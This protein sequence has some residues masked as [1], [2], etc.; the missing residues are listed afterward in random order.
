MVSVVHARLFQ[1][2]IASL[3]IIATG[4]GI[5]AVGVARAPSAAAAPDAKLAD[6]SG[7]QAGNIIDD[8]LF[9]DSNALSEAGIQAFLNAKVPTCAAGF[10]CL[11]NYRET[12]H[13]IAGTP[14][15]AQYDG[16]A[17]ESAATIIFKVAQTCGISPKVLLVVLQKEQGLVT[18]SS[19][20][21]TRFRAAMG[22]GCPDTAAC[23]ANYYG[24]FNQVHYGAYL[25]KRYTQPAGTGPGTAYTTRF[26]LRYPVG[27][28]S[29]IATDTSPDCP[30]K[31]VFIENQATHALYIYTPYTPDA[32]AL[33]T[34]YGTGGSCSSYGNRNFYSYYTDWF[35]SVRGAP[36]GVYF[37]DYYAAN[38]SWLGYPTSP[39]SCAGPDRGCIQKFQGGMIA[40]SYSTVAAGVRADYAQYWGWY[41]REYGEMGYPTSEY[42]CVGDQCRQEFQGG[43]ITSSTAAGI[44]V[45]L[46]S[47]PSWLGASTQAKSCTLKGGACYQAFQNGWVLQSPSGSFAVPTAVLA[48]WGNYGREYEFLGFPTGAT[49][50]VPGPTGSYTQTFQ[51]GTITVTNGAGAVTA[52]SEP[53][54]NASL[55]SPWLGAATQAKSCTL[56][57]GAC[58]QA[59]QNGWV[60]QS[61]SGTYALPTVVRTIWG[62]YGREYNVLGFPTGSPSADPASGTYTQAFQGGTVSV[63]NGTATVSLP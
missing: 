34:S 36:V 12:T 21:V 52:A 57:G 7:F 35:G 38:T 27:R 11:K 20:G 4:I 8:G 9:W 6:M 58:Y 24:F 63:V 25:L 62:W 15:C 53:F 28:T 60:V 54:I 2:M 59:F 3:A 29:A 19:P 22:A 13:T 23:D 48:T 46:R 39:M 42:A 5:F 40:G 10:T 55:T 41:G 49:S 14:M 56:K 44:A 50:T 30:T 33:A 26:D 37:R 31:S 16:A 32:A 18:H 45:E 51:G 61:P 17:N 1:A 43:T 47:R